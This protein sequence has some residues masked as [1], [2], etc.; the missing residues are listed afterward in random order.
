M[1]KEIREVFERNGL[2]ITKPNQQSQEDVPVFWEGVVG[3]KV[4]PVMLTEDPNYIIEQMA[5]MMLVMRGQFLTEDDGDDADL[6]NLAIHK[7]VNPTVLE[8][9]VLTFEMHNVSLATT[10]QQ[11]RHRFQ[12]FSQLSTRATDIQGLDYRIP[13]TIALDDELR[14]DFQNIV[15]LSKKFY[16][17][18]VLKG[19]P[20]QDA[21][22][23]TPQSLATSIWVTGNY[24]SWQ[25]FYA[26]RSCKNVQWEI[27]FI[28]EEVKRLITEWH[29]LF[30]GGLVMPC[31]K[32][33]K[34]LYQH[35]MF[36]PCDPGAVDP[37]VEYIFSTDKRGY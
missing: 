32:A 17:K 4:F 35:N 34:C 29:P 31:A 22:Y 15:E 3:L 28:A 5:K 6:V 21:R 7:G 16:R 20:Y 11:V 8:S 10:H 19:I 36:P 25:D 30:G 1:D 13:K 23:I 33:G 27:N 9:L 24:R 14:Q 26:Q 2:M 12:G 18:A 37:A